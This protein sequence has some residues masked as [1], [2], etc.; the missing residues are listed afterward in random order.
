MGEKQVDLGMA[1]TVAHLRDRLSPYLQDESDFL[2]FLNMAGPRLYHLGYWRD[3]IFEETIVTDHQYISLHREAESILA[4]TADNFPAEMNAQWQDYKTTGIPDNGPSFLYGVTDDGL[5]PVIMDLNRESEYGYNFHLRPTS[6]KVLLP[7][8]GVVTI[9]YEKQNGDIGVEVCTLTGT[10]DKQT[11]YPDEER[12]IK[13]LDIRYDGCFDLVQ[14][15]AVENT[16]NTE[17]KLSEGRG[18]EISRYRRFRMANPE[19][20]ERTVSVLMKR[21]WIDLLAEDDVVY[22]SDI[23]ALKHALLAIVAEDNAD[24]ERAEY[25]WNTARQQLEAEKDAYRGMVKPK[26]NFDPFGGSAR[27]MHNVL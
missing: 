16:T 5:H 11:S 1:S 6:P 3:L 26:V 25:H 13:I 12:A 24:L 21:K 23:N 7:S 8:E 19:N 17:T 10:A 27:R 9:K 22:L 15:I 4:A 2:H 20:I 14:V 18:N